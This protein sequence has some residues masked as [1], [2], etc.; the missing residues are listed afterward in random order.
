MKGGLMNG[1]NV[2]I[3][4]TCILLLGLSLMMLSG[5]GAAEVMTF[6]GSWG[7]P[8]FQLVSQRD[9]GV[10]I[11]YSMGSLR[12]EQM[13]IDG[14]PMQMLAISGVML[15]NDEGAPNLPGLGRYIA[16]PRGAEAR[17]EVLE[18]RTQVLRNMDIAPAPPI[19]REGDD[20]PV[21][22]TKDPAIYSAN[23]DYPREPIAMSRPLKMRGVDAVIVGITPFQYNPVSKDLLVYTDVRVRVTFEGGEGSFGVDRYRSR[24]WEPVLRANLLNYSSLA[25][26]DFGRRNAAKQTGY[27]YVILVPDDPDFIAW[28][29]TIKHWRTLQGISTEVF[30]LTE[31][32]SSASEI[33]SFIND[34]Y[35]TWDIPPVAVLLLSDYPSSGK[36]YGITSPLWSSYCVSDN[37]YADV[38]GDDLPEMNFAR[39]TAQDAADLELMVNKF[40]GYERNPYTDAGFYDNP[41]CAGGWQT[42][43]WFILCSEVIYGFLANELGKSPVREYA[44]YSGVPGSEWSTNANTYMIVDYFGPD[45]LGYIPATPEHLTDWGANATRMNNDINSGCFIV[46]HR[47]HGGE[48][49]WGEPDY[50]NTH[51]DGLTNT[52]LPFVF[53]INCLTG[54]YNWGSECFTEK[55]HRIE[56]GALGLIGASE[57][58]Y[59]FVNDTYVWGMYDCMWPEFMPDYPAKGKNVGTDNLRP[60][61]A[62]VAGKYFLAASSWPYNPSEKTVTYHLFHLHGDAFTTFYSE[63]P[64]SLTVSHPGVL[65]IGATSFP[66][67]ADDGS[68]IA[69]T[70]DGQ[71][72]GTADGTGSAVSVPITP[73]SMPGTMLVTV[74]KYNHYRYSQSVPVL[75]P[76]GPFVVHYKHTVDDDDVGSSSGNG[77]GV[78][79]PGESIELFPFWVKNYGVDTAFTVQGELD[80]QVADPYIT[81]VDT[82]DD[83]GAI[84]PDDS[85]LGA[86]GYLF[87]VDMAAPNGHGISFVLHCTDGDS[88]WP[89]YFGEQVLAPILEYVDN[90]I[91]DSGGGNG[92]GRL[93]PGETANMTITAKNV[94]G[95]AA[96]GIIGILVSLDPDLTVSTATASYPDLNPGGQG[97]SLTDYVVEVSPAAPS[98]GQASLEIALVEARGFTFVDTFTVR[99]GM[100]Q[101]LFVDDDEGDSYETY[102]TDA[103]D[104]LGIDY[105]VWTVTSQGSPGLAVM[106]EYI[107]V[108]WNT[109]VDYSYTLS[110]TDEANLMAYLDGKGTLFLSSQDYL[111]DIGSP[112]TFSTN[113]LHVSSWTSDVGVTAV[114]GIPADPIADGLNYTL[115]YPYYNW[116]DQIVPDAS[117]AGIFEITASKSPE[118]QRPPKNGIPPHFGETQPGPSKQNYCALRYPAEGDSIYQVVF[119]AFPFESVPTAE[120]RTELMQRILDW[121]QGDE[122]PPV[123]TVLAPNGGE[124]WPVGTEHDVEFLATD[125]SGLDSIS[126]FLSLDGGN[127]FADTIV[128][129]KPQ[130][131]PYR[132]TVPP[133]YSD[134]AVIKVAAY[135]VYKNM[136]WDISDSLF[137]TADMIPP[138]DVD[139]LSVDIFPGG[140]SSS[141]NLLLWWSPVEDDRGVA[142]YIVYRGLDPYLLGDSLAAPAETTYVD[143]GALGDTLNNFFY[144]V[145]AVDV[146][147]NKSG[148]SNCVGEY[149]TPLTNIAPPDTTK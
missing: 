78:I 57:T 66:V 121:V 30:T 115:S 14:Q 67:T 96:A 55:F 147:A 8:G 36:A 17:L 41:V 12:I 95:A 101:V 47:D 120:D 13:D 20:S 80:L 127:T 99:I 109:G 124:F 130:A 75:P 44:I 5:T 110:S 3:L 60:G 116:S 45:G 18:T 144:V 105:D 32:G 106:Q 85:A 146:G 138:G 108:I 27:E 72:I 94:G 77:D 51:L 63:V 87:D 113:Y 93:D 92:D 132:W 73:Q 42:E 102:F 84:A 149:D 35:N 49:G 111:Y 81:L 37:I 107:T 145:K 28:A 25:E 129:G 21:V 103:L 15:P 122:Q 54:K 46:Q 64:Q 4:R 56:H 59:S 98:P 9:D 39:I 58:S 143:V 34:A 131:S 65:Y 82:L 52:M 142:Y 1:V 26:V 43:R 22:Y 90:Q 125:P 97:A 71:I 74:T 61:F 29:D 76:E 134:S 91:D 24:H 135:D 68:V 6:E 38:D 100:K 126:L 10:D 141:G 104:D 137:A 62:N 16:I 50:Q 48:T 70:V 139:D 118:P 133:L 148:D 119:L 53:S 40:L 114:T 2:R 89:S 69:L 79:N 128:H 140:K 136:G 11:I 88:I 31:T 7:T 123:V 23:E 33:E 112:T 86:A 19:P 83:Y 117:A